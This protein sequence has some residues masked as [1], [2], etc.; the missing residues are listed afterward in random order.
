[1]GVNM[2]YVCYESFAFRFCSYLPTLSFVMDSEKYFFA[3]KAK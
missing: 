1:M 3:R 2:A